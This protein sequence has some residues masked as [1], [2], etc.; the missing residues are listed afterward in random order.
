MARDYYEILGVPRDAS[1]KQ[2]KDAYRK[3][4]K[5]HHPDR[6]PGDK[7]AEARFKEIQ[8]A[9]DV[10]S[11]AKKRAQYDRFG[12]DFE[13]AASGAGAGGPGGFEF[14]WGG[15]GGGPA[16]FDFSGADFGDAGSIF[17]EILGMR[18]GR[19]AGRRGGRRR[20]T[21]PPQDVEQEI[22]V[23][24]LTAAKGGA[25]ELSVQ[26]PNGTGGLSSERL[27]VNIPAGVADGA[28]LRLAGQGEAGG[29]LYVRVRIRPHPYFRREGQDVII[30]LPL[31]LAEAILGTK[32]DVPT[33]DGTI[34]LTIPPGTS[35]GQRLRLRG[36]G[37][38]RPGKG[39][40]RGDQFVEVRVM[41]PRKIDDR[42]R[43]LIDEFARRNPQQPRADVPWG[44]K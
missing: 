31:S 33:I 1:E 18:G 35:S 44:G 4:A 39:G 20:T 40:E 17:E 41:V 11:D 28:R 3:L 14:H 34:T 26:R 27:S 23:D 10:L 15:P 2:L 16:G 25:L 9:Y 36:Q 30:E 12:A 42:S 19:A 24:F 32:V 13:R 6:N 43:E 37:L 7:Q 29:D 22:D 38:P 21:A 5:Q 8:Q